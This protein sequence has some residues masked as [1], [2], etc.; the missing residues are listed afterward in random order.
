MKTRKGRRQQW[1]M[2]LASMSDIAFLLIIFFAVAGRFTRSEQKVTLPTVLAGDRMKPRDLEITVPNDGLLTLN[3]VPMREPDDLI[4]ALR[5]F[6]TPD[7]SQEARTVVVYA[8]AD[9][10]WRY[11]KLAVEA[12]NQADGNLEIA[13]RTGR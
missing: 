4:D 13:V 9:T 12:V 3:G 7:M 6:I 8:D 5:G 1:N 11:T 10:P 2:S